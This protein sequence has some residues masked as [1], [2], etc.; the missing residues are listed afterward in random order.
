V[1]EV[2]PFQIWDVRENEKAPWRE[3]KV[4]SVRHDAVELQFLDM[5][6]APLSAQIFNGSCKRMLS[7]RTRY[8]LVREAEPNRSAFSTNAQRIPKGGAK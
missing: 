5:P 1:S 2:K 6:N 8:R 7:D 4:T 3:V